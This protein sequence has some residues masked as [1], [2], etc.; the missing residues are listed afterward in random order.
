[1]SRWGRFLPLAMFLAVAG[2][3]GGYLLASGF[4]GYDSRSLP[5]AIIGQPAPARAL[6]GLDGGPGFGPEELS[7]P[8]VK[9]V[10]VFASWCA[11]CRVEHPLLVDLQRRGVTIYG[12]NHRD[13]PDAARAFLNELGD[14]YAA[15]GVD[16]D[17]RASVDWGVYGVPETFVVDG[18][19]RVSAKHVGPL[20]PDALERTILP[21]LNAAGS[22]SGG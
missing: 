20:T 6:P 1:M 21:A 9:L 13:A 14:P 8:G 5:S 10:N 12:I 4:L 11:P 22:G 2:V 16:P 17:G 19:G 15:V 18:E 7:A 3:M